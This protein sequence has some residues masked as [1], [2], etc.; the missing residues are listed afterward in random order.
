VRRVLTATAI[1]VGVCVAGSACQQSPRSTSSP[2]PTNS[3]TAPIT[4]VRTVTVTASPVAPV[5]S[6][7][8]D[9]SGSGD[10]V[11]TVNLGQGGYT[12][13]YTDSSGF[14][15]VEPVSRD[16]S[17]GSAIINASDNSGVATCASTGP[18]TLQFRNGGEWTLRFVPLS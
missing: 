3:V 15:I 6:E 14:L 10:T 8:V 1:A 17:T 5:A 7:P 13:Q 12:V 2:A 11:K 4:S 9:V 18:V 16:G